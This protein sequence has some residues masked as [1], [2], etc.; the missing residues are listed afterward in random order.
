M[1]MRISAL[2]AFAALLLSSAGSPQVDVRWQRLQWPIPNVLGILRERSSK[3]L[4][5]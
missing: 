2:I 4:L 3:E 1:A 5:H